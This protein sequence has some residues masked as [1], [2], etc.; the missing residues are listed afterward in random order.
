[1]FMEDG[2]ISHSKQNKRG[3]S[4][5]IEKW[6][7]SAKKYINVCKVCGSQGYSPAIL[8]DD[9]FDK[10]WNVHSANKMTYRELTKTLKPL[11]L[12]DLGRCEVCAAIQDCI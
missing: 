5:Y 11:A 4:L 12:D 9:F 3:F 7:P 8:A 6:N 1:M 2:T 10:R